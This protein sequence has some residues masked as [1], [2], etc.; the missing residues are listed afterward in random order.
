MRQLNFS[1][2]STYRASA[3]SAR[4]SVG[5]SPQSG[6]GVRVARVGGVQVEPDAGLVAPVQADALSAAG[7]GDGAAAADLEVEALR[8]VLRA[9]V[10]LAAV[11]GD[12]L[13]ADD[14]VAGLQ[15]ARDRG[16]RGEVVGDER[17]RHPRLPADDGALADLGPAQVARVLRRAVA[18]CARAGR[19]RKRDR[20]AVRYRWHLPLQGAM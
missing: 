19:V 1:Y 12:D 3:R 17:V 2:P 10:A 15:V 6:A 14:V 7:R 9:V 5:A 18:C 20:L 4:L 13:V 8:V 16:R 11:Q